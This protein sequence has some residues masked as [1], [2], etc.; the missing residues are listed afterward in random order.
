M[1][2]AYATIKLLAVQQGRREIRVVVNQVSVNG[3]G[4]TI[5]KQ[6]Q[7]VVDRFVCPTLDEGRGAAVPLELLGEIPTD[8]SVRE[9]VQKRQLLLESMPGAPAPASATR[10]ARRDR[11][12]RVA[13]A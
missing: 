7:L 11:R 12:R 4:R 2:D 9:A 13:L 1:T 3:E 8:F 5:R 10:S 6:L